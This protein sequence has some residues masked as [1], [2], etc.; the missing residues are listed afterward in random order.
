MTNTISKIGLVIT[1]AILAVASYGML[2]TTQVDAKGRPG[3]DKGTI[4]DIAVDNGN[5]TTL[6]TALTCTGLLPLFDGTTNRQFTVFAPTDAAF[7][8]AGLNAGNVCAFPGI[9]NILAYH[10][11]PGVKTSQN[12]L[13]RSSMNMLNGD[14]AQIANGEIGGAALTNTLDLR[15]TNG[16]VH[17]LSEV[18][19]P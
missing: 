1:G 19:L 16:V 9:A 12:V 15:A 17:V 3:A 6:A 10:V 2:A 5:F 11:T 7:T 14:R 4:V 13:N 8:A 18:M